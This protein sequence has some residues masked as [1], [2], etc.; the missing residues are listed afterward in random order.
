MCGTTADAMVR[1]L[2]GS[3]AS[4]TSGRR[5]LIL[6][7]NDNTVFLRAITYAVFVVDARDLNDRPDREPFRMASTKYAVG[8][9]MIGDEARPDSRGSRPSSSRTCR[10]QS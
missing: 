10:V 6:L 3:G 1:I 7:G 2:G 8:C 5:A 9:I 4:A